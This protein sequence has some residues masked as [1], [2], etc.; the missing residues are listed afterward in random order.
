MD[1][2]ALKKVLVWYWENTSIFAKVC[3]S[4]VVTIICLLYSCI[5]NPAGAINHFMIICIDIIYSI[6]PSTPSE[7]TIGY[8]LTQFA[9]D[10]PNIGWGIVYEVFSGMSV[11]FGL[12]CVVT[13]YKLMPFI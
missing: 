13:L 1:I 4:S 11:M 8:M 6:F 10:Y 2:L 3:M 7:F 5:T 12:W 9:N